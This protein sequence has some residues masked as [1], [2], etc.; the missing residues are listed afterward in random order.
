MILLSTSPIILKIFF[1]TNSF[2]KVNS[3]VEDV[4][5]KLITDETNN[6]L[7]MLPSREEVKNVVFS[8]NKDGAPGPDG[9]GATFFQHYWNI[10]HS[11][12]FNAVIQFF[13]NG[14]IMPNYNANTIVVIPKVDNVEFVEQFRLMALANFKF[15]FITKILADRLATIMSFIISEEQRGF[16]K[17]RKI[18]DCILL[19]SEV[20]NFLHKTTYG[21]NLA[22]K[23]NIS[24]VFDTLD[25]NFL[26]KVLQS[27]GF[28]HKFCLWIK[29]IL[30]S[31][32]LSVFINGAKKMLF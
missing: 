19:T 27:F 23:I 2:L 3:L 8:L 26:N 9:F 29:N 12:V 13:T 30:E 25:W 17:G 18:K 16:I 15:K 11:D 24:K 31:A 21:G 1:P 22:M 28:N 6:M 10:I 20:A 14:W 5:P 7:T 4:V 32:T